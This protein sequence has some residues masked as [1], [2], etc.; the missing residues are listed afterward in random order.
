MASVFHV[1]SCM[2]LL[3]GAYTCAVTASRICLVTASFKGPSVAGGIAHANDQLVQVLIQANHHV[4]VLYANEYMEGSSPKWKQLAQQEGYL[5]DQISKEEQ[6]EAGTANM[7]KAF[8]SYLW[9]VEHEDDFDVI[10][11]HDYMG[12]GFYVLR[13]REMN[14]HFQDKTV[15]TVAHWLTALTPDDNTIAS[16]AAASSATSIERETTI[17]MERTTLQLSDIVVFPSQWL[18]DRITEFGWQLPTS[19]HIL[20]NPVSPVPITTSD[21]LAWI[22]DSGA[23]AFFG[24]LEDRKGKQRCSPRSRP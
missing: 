8:N 7:K 18:L 16:N 11:F 23:V 20:P 6:L 21:S 13:A 2:A 15:I 9:L 4:H 24:R 3:L 19:I 10:Q 17:F 12:L 5:F 22:P 14:L 1:L